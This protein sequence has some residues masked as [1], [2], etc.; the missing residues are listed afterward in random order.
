MGPSYT[1]A[2]G[3]ARRGLA[4]ADADKES[5]QAEAVCA[6]TGKSQ[7]RSLTIG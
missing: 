1:G 4:C 2:G 7:Q 3:A 5:K 6:G